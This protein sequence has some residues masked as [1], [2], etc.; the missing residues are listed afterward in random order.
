RSA[1]RRGRAARIVRRRA[2]RRSRG[3]TAL[4]RRPPG[5]RSLSCPARAS[6]D[7]R[8]HSGRP[9][10][11]TPRATPRP[12]CL[13]LIHSLTLVD[14]APPA[15]TS[16][17]GATLDLKG[18]DTAATSVRKAEARCASKLAGGVRGGG[19]QLK[20]VH[21]KGVHIGGVKAGGVKVGPVHVP[22]ASPQK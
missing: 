18:V 6:R 22:G 14:R 8:A 10:P 17:R 20:G 5:G 1:V 7:A 16:S 3:L 19:V 11:P 15:R 13:T 4:K 12:P 21:V 2:A 9:P